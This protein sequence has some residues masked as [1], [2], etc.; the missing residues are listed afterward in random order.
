MPDHDFVDAA[1]H[2][3]KVVA[4]HHHRNATGNLDVFDGAAQ[5]GFGLGEGLAIFLSENAAEVVN[6]IFEKLLKFEKRL[7][8]I[9]G[10]GAAPFGKSGSGGFD[11][12]VGFGNGGKRGLSDDFAGGGIGDV[13]PFGGVGVDPLAVDKI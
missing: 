3:F 7:D 2:V 5:L 12:G 6:M 10:R 11:G 13:E 8:A 1:G 9:F 4:L